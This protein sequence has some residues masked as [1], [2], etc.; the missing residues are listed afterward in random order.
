[1]MINLVG[2]NRLDPRGS[3]GKNEDEKHMA[4]TNQISVLD[5]ALITC[6]NGVITSAEIEGIIAQYESSLKDPNLLETGKNVGLFNGLLRIINNTL[7]KPLF[8]DDKG[9]ID[10]EL[11]DSIFSYIYIPLCYRYSHIP[12][13]HNFLYHLIPIDISY[14]YDIKNGI[15]RHTGNKV[16]SSYTAFLVK[17][18]RICDSDLLDYIVHTSSIGGIFRAKT[19]GYREEQTV[20]L[21]PIQNTAKIGEKELQEIA[22]KDDAPT[23]PDMDL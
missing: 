18:D 13:I 11:M 22:E 20:Y 15:D 10:Y 8:K 2:Y 5:N 12:S 16:N 7:I 3:P 23:L 6:K 21:A 4:T 17:W 1:M 9:R 14:A 19:K